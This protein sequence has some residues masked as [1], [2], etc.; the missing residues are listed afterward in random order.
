MLQFLGKKILL[1]I[2]NLLFTAILLIVLVYFGRQYKGNTFVDF[3][4]GTLHSSEKVGFNLKYSYVYH[5]NMVTLV[6][7]KAFKSL[8][9]IFIASI[10]AIVLAILVSHLMEFMF[11]KLANRSIDF[12]LSLS[13]IV[14]FHFFSQMKD[15]SSYCR[16]K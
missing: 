10:L 14:I 9:Y 2:I 15:I 4:N 1:A 3:S 13:L 8:G 16:I 6:L 7:R 5:E 12:L 11:G